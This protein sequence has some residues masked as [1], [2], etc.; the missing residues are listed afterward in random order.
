[1][2]RELTD[3]QK[4]NKLRCS[5]STKA[6]NVIKNRYFDEYQEVYWKLLREHGLQPTNNS[7]HMLLLTEENRKLK[8]MLKELSDNGGIDIIEFE[9]DRSWNYPKPKEQDD[10]E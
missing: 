6:S 5:L 7:N 9:D 4:S 10:N 1:M 2:S 3:T 8:G